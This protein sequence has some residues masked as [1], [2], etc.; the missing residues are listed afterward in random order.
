VP[1]IYGNIRAVLGA[2]AGDRIA[3]DAPA[4]AREEAR[5]TARS[6]AG[7]KGLLSASGD[8]VGAE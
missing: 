7:V 5:V 6:G 8:G 2:L 4:E 1:S 3:P